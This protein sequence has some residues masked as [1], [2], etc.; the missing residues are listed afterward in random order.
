MYSK[1]SGLIL[2]FHGCDKSVRDKIVSVKGVVL[3]ASENDYDWLGH[4][5]YFWENNHE[6][7][8]KFAQDLKNNPPKGK[9]NL[10]KEPSVLGVVIDLG[11]C[12]DLLDSKFLE[13]LKVGYN[14]LC[15][16]HEEYGTKLPD[17]IINNEGE[18]LRRNLDCAVIQTVHEMNKKLGKPNYDSVR[19]VFF[20]GKDLYE[21]AGFKEKNHIQ[22]AVRNQNC[23]KGFFI[24]RDFDE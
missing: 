1:R 18:L 17:N 22:I 24:P 10:I 9:E 23:I 2:G 14:F 11:Y 5:V 19:G 21:N 7:A 6:R 16:S 8:L 4:G 13:V 12:L 15:T 3:K 20:E